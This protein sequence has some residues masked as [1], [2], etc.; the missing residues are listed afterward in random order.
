MQ[1]GGKLLVL[2]IYFVSFKRIY[3]NYAFEVD[4]L[5]QIY[6][7]IDMSFIYLRKKV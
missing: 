5:Q 4:Y 3:P 2:G 7:V 6:T 1:L